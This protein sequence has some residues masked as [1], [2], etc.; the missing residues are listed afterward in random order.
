[1][2]KWNI[3]IIE[4]FE[5]I[6]FCNLQIFSVFRIAI[7]YIRHLQNTLECSQS[8][9]QSSI[10]ESS[11][12]DLHAHVWQTQNQLAHRLVSSLPPNAHQTPTTSAFYT[13]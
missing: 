3:L 2:N 4:L 10:Y 8:N 7:S 11:Y 12:P 9:A 6:N 13:S 1:M 5:P